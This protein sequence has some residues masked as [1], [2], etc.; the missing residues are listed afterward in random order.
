MDENN[1]GPSWMV[2][3]LPYVEQDN[4][5]KQVTVSI[6]NYQAFS[7]P[8]PT[9]ATGSNDQGWRNI[10][11]NNVKSYRCPSESNFDVLGNRNSG[12][13]AR[14]NYAAN[15]GPGDPNAAWNGGSG[16]YNYGLQSGGVMCPNWGA[17]IQRI[18]D[19]SSNTIMINH[20]RVGPAA[21]D[22]RGCWAF[23]ITATTYGNAYGDCYTPNDTGCC[24]D[25]VAG[26]ND[27]PDIAMGCWNGGYGQMQARAAHSGC[28]LATLGDGSVR[29]IRNSI[30]QRTWYIML[31]RNDGQ[32][33][34]V[35]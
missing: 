16:T 11:S 10:R 8:N 33:Y 9:V 5:Y 35:N 13:W 31:S 3:L 15:S 1:I 6:A 27:R 34:T 23:G 7:I 19:G 25:D 12:N 24:S 2:M 32:S 30:D 28:V 21:N 4:L 20:V 26:C 14:G 22:M 29:T 17:A 18:E